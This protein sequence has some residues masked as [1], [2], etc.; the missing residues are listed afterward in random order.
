[1]ALCSLLC[2]QSVA[3]AAKPPLVLVPV[4]GAG[5]TA[6]DKE[7]YRIALQESLSQD[8]TVY[9]GGVVATKLQ[10]SVSKNCD[11]T[12]CL[13]EVAIAFQG[14]LIGRLV[15]TP[16]GNGYLLAL[17]IKNIFDDKVVVSQNIPC[18]GCNQY[19]VIQKLRELD[20]AMGAPRVAKTKEESKGIAWYWWALG[21]VAVGV[22]AG[23]GGGGSEP[24][25]A[26]TGAVTV[27]W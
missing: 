11:I 19:A 10:K 27:T 5:L 3:F 9:S 17:E 21:A 23:G 26:Q 6:E 13:Q 4:Q 7:N 18:E 14:E 25:P 12:E 16:D 15:V 8:Y 1:M 2:F 24:P 22:A 20:L